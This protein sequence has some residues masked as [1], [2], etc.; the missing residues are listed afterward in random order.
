MNE[1]TKSIE[2]N[3]RDAFKIIQHFFSFSDLLLTIIILFISKFNM[4]YIQKL[5]YLVGLDIIIRIIKLYIYHIQDSYIKELF[6]S[7]FTC[8]QFFLIIT[9]FNTALS[10]LYSNLMQNETGNSEFIVF[11]AIFFFNF[12]NR[13]IIFLWI[14]NILF[15]Q[16]YNIIFVFIFTFI[17]ICRINIRIIWKIKKEKHSL[18]L[19]IYFD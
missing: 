13:K 6:L 12:P 19:Y 15:F 14:K 17:N 4:K 16:M 2:K 10:N 7:I 9:F 8:C 1:I 11:T 5:L 3:H 18:L